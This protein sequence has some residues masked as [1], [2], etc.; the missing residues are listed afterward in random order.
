MVKTE[1]QSLLTPALP[2]SP[3]HLSPITHTHTVGQVLL[4]SNQSA[5]PCTG[6]P[7]PPTSVQVLSWKA[8]E[9]RADGDLLQARAT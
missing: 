1:F 9:P 3:S 2:K 4:C 7:F 6:V 8:Q 5:H